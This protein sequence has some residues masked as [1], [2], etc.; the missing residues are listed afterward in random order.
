MFVKMARCTALSSLRGVEMR[1]TPPVRL[2][3]SNS[4]YAEPLPVPG[5]MSEVS[6]PVL[7][8]TSLATSARVLRDGTG[9]FGGFVAGFPVRYLNRSR[10]RPKY[11]PVGFH[12]P[13]T[14]GPGYW[15]V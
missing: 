4:I 1:R 3:I 5:R 12:P 2:G 13:G 11:H 8:P 9:C 6:S 14:L 7:T 10:K 15:V